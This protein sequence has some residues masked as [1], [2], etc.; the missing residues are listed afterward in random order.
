[1]G[2]S[3]A[4][5]VLP[6]SC[7]FFIVGVSYVSCHVCKNSFNLIV[8]SESE[9]VETPHTNIT[10]PNL[11]YTDFKIYSVQ[12]DMIRE[13]PKFQRQQPLH[14]ESSAVSVYSRV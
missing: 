1:M 4:H 11:E 3:D 8:E 9:S 13:A 12:W 7:S 2:F 6:C 14:S 5:D 10:S